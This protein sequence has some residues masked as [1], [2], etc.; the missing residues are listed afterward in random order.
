MADFR[1]GILIR[2]QYG[3]EDDLTARLDELMEQARLA[4]ALGFD[5]LLKSSH[6]S[7]HPSIEFQQIPLI[8][9]LAAE[10]PRMRIGA[11][12]ALLPLHKPLDLAEQFATLEVI[13]QRA[14]HRAGR[15]LDS[16]MSKAELE[17][18]ETHARLMG[19]CV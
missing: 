15:D 8:A 18:R 12:V 2:G 6:Y 19:V 10:A 5:C 17:V 4:Q 14:F 13:T 9:R 7:T 1:F 11:G 3:P 16:E